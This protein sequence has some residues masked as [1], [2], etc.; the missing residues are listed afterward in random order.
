MS[1]PKENWREPLSF[2]YEHIV[3]ELEYLGYERFA[4]HVER[5]G[6]DCRD[7]NVLEEEWRKRYQALLERLYVY[8]PPQ[9][10]EP[11]SYRAPPES[12]G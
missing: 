10:N 4:R 5:L 9:R 3:R 6:R 11:R 8:E 2:T 7:K 12:D 1:R